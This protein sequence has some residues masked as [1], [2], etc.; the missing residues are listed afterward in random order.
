MQVCENGVL[1]E[2]VGAAYPVAEFCD[3]VDNDC[4]GAIDEDLECGSC[5][6][7]ETEVCFSGDPAQAAVGECRPGLQMCDP[8]G[9]VFGPCMDDVGPQPELCNTLDD[10]CD[11]LADEEVLDDLPPCMVGRGVCA[12]PGRWVCTLDGRVCEGEAGPASVESCDGTDEDCDGVIDEDFEVGGPCDLGVGA[13]AVQG[14]LACGPDGVVVCMGEP[15]AGGDENVCNGV[16]DDCDGQVDE[17]FACYR[18][19]PGT[20]NV[21]ACRAGRMTC[22]AGCVGEALPRDEICNGADD[23]CDGDTDENPDCACT[24]GETVECYEGPGMPGIGVCQRGQR[25]CGANFDWG[26]CVGLVGPSEETCDNTDQDCDGRIDEGVTRACGDD[27][28]RCRRGTQRCID[29]RFDATCEGEITPR[30]EQCN[31]QDDDCD[32]RTDEGTERVCG[33]DAG[34]CRAGQQ[35]CVNGAYGGCDG[36]ISPV[37]E[38]C[39]GADQDCDGRNDEGTRN[40]CGECGPEPDEICNDNDDD[41]DGRTDENVSNACGE[42]GPVP[43]EVCDGVDNDCDGRTDEN[44]QNACGGCGPVGDEV[45]D[46]I[47]N[48]CDGQT[49]E[50]VLNACGECGALPQ[51]ACNNRDDDCDGRT[52]EGVQNAC[53]ACGPEPQELCNNRDDDCDNRVDENVANACGECGPVPDEV[54][55]NRDDDCDG[56]TDEGVLNACGGCGAVPQESCNDRDDDC[57]GRTDEGVQNACG[58]CGDVPDEICN[59]RDDDCDGDTDEGVLNACGECGAVPEEICDGIDNDCDR[60]VDER[61]RNRCG[62]CGPVPV[63]VCNNRDDDC[64]GTIDEGGDLVCQQRTRGAA[65]TCRAGV[66]TCGRNPQCGNGFCDAG[67]CCGDGGNPCR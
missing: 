3:T 59:G 39:D 15:G 8:V 43:E 51:E 40:R 54:C 44:V 58:G 63:E 48:D 49:D 25:T 22:D 61:V 17:A 13:C 28:G 30:V 46:N 35:L 29:G 31:G 38:V 64:D 12:A 11:G 56:D 23:D 14:R 65:D 66:C 67:F 9:R 5:E 36:A 16:D 18:G 52:D 32:S 10:D 53:G 45:C 37:D 6:E 60:A 26:P 1:S 27:T 34:A 7:G 55:N 47:D 62:E 33:I 4:D 42:C 41:C 50:N 57:D 2:C 19:P 20:E 24:P 21:G